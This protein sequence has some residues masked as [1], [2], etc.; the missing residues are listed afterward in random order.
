MAASTI[1]LLAPIPVRAQEESIHW[2]YA[3]IFGTGR[4]SLD[5]QV[6]TTVIGATPNW[7]RREPVLAASGDKIVGIRIRMPVSLGAHD[8][9]SLQAIEGLSLSSV[10]AVSVVPGVEIE[11]P[12]SDRWSLKS[13]NYAGFGT[14]IRGGADARIFRAGFRSSLKFDSEKSALAFVTGLERFG[15]SASGGDSDA[16]NLISAG[17]DVER[18]LSDTRIGNVPVAIHWHMLYSH[19]LDSLGFD[20][21]SLDV[22]PTLISSEWELGGRF[23]SPRFATRLR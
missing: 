12:M 9:S 11:I 8:V 22:D 1:A 4:Y 2:A 5:G 20:L 13:L 21:S 23:Q 3:S 7:V 16:I 14:E 10:N 15:Y 6:E 17:I 19:Y 18:P